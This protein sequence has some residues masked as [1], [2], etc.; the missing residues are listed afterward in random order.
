M[1]GVLGKGLLP[2]NLWVVKRFWVGSVAIVLGHE[3]G[4][5]VGV[6]LFE[7][8]EPLVENEFDLFG[9]GHCVLEIGGWRL[10]VGWSD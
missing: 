1:L 7:G 6:P 3:L 9:L 4:E 10:R 2:V 8:R 5:S